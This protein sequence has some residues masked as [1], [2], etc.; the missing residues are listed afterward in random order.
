MSYS[1]S[2]LLARGV[3]R[4]EVLALA[5]AAGLGKFTDDDY[6]DRIYSKITVT[7]SGCWECAGFQHKLRNVKTHDRGYVLLSYRGTQQMA[8]RLSYRLFVGPV[9]DDL[10]VCHRCDNPPCV[11]PKHLFLGD[12]IANMRDMADKKRNK[13]GRTHCIHGHEFNAENTILSNG[14]RRR[15]CRACFQRL[16][17]TEKYKAAARERQR[18]R[19]VEKRAARQAVAP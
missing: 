8:H 3:R 4:R 7:E 2:R 14:G 18:R 6:R 5:G 12:Q 1:Q 10:Q 9:P 13:A 19:R 11:N 16:N 17:Q 15:S